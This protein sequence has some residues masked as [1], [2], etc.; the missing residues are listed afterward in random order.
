MEVLQAIDPK[1]VVDAFGVGVVSGL[2]FGVLALFLL[3]IRS[4]VDWTAAILFG[5]GP[6]AGCN[7]SFKEPLVWSGAT[8][9]GLA[10]GFVLLAHGDAPQSPPLSSDNY[11]HQFDQIR[12]AFEAGDGRPNLDNFAGPTLD[13]ESEQSGSDL[14]RQMREFNREISRGARE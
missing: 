4:C 8:L 6:K 3:F 11:K 13:E 5:R 14:R 9:A 12:D 2:G 7:F 1:R 10:I